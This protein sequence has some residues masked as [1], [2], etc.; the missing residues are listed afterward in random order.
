MAMLF[1]RPAAIVP[2]A[3]LAL[4]VLLTGC[5]GGS[6]SS[7]V[8]T[9]P[10]PAACKKLSGGEKMACLDGAAAAAQEEGAVMEAEPAAERELA[11]EG[12]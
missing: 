6:G 12:Q 3:L 8:V 2:A 10:V 9:V 1:K 5:G 11:E 7:T 4:G